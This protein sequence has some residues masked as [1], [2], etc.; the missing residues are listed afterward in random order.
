LTPASD[1]TGGPVRVTTSKQARDRALHAAL[2]ST[3]VR[4]NPVTRD[5]L[6]KIGARLAE[7]DR[8][9]EQ[10]AAEPPDA[11]PPTAKDR[12]VKT[13]DLPVEDIPFTRTTTPL[14]FLFLVA[15][16]SAMALAFTSIIDNEAARLPAAF[17]YLAAVLAGYVAVV[18]YPPTA[19]KD[20]QDRAAWRS[21]VTAV[22]AQFAT[23]VPGSALWSLAHHPDRPVSYVRHID[24]HPRVYTLSTDADGTLEL[25]QYATPTRVGS[26]V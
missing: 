4:V 26:S 7:R 17:S 6:R 12:P 3:K 20:K 21:A 8:L 19:R 23:T 24:G 22:E 11:S 25:T 10:T 13:A 5:E 18:Y 16:I 15:A 14:T 2:A 9:R 1:D